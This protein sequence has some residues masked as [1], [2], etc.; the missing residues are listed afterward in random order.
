[1]SLSRGFR[2]LFEASVVE[3]GVTR[4]GNRMHAQCS[5]QTREE[6]DDLLEG[7][8]ASSREIVHSRCLHGDSVKVKRLLLLLPVGPT[9]AM[10]D[11]SPSFEA[12]RRGITW[13]ADDAPVELS[14]CRK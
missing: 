12:S 8:S 4:P 9:S 11:S 1:M 7:R 3:N 13:T 10:P 2:L 6:R 5:Q 14:F